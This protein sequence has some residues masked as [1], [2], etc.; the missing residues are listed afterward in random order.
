MTEQNANADDTLSLQTINTLKIL[1]KTQEERFDRIAKLAQRL[2]NVPIAILNL[3]DEGLFWF[4]AA[5]DFEF[6]EMRQDSAFCDCALLG[7]AVFV[8]EDA[9]RDDRFR[10]EPLVAGAPGVR[11]YAGCPVDAADG[12]RRGTLCVLDTVPREFGPNEI[13]SMR[14]LGHM[15]ED[16]LSALTMATTDDLTKLANWRGFRMIAEPMISLCKRA[17]SPAAVAMFDLDGLKE[18]NDRYGHGAGDAAIKNFGKLLLKVFRNSDVV[19]RVGGDEFCVLL[20]DPEEAKADVPLTRL[21]ERV[22]AFNRDSGEDY[23]L[24]FSAGLVS[25]DRDSHASVE[26][27]L[28][29]ADRRMYLQKHFRRGAKQQLGAV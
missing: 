2:L 7:D 27:L 14:E 6:P 12:Q 5:E 20:T 29:D 25:F 10:D 18:I 1:D 26:D 16:E 22:D 4:K 21:R 3:R 11:F 9:T 15:V 23:T 13:D 19:A 8:V 17:L 28:R 24:S